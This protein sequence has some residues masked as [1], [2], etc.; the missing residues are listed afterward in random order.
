MLQQVRRW[1]RWIQLLTCEKLQERNTFSCKYSLSLLGDVRSWSVSSDT[2]S[3]E[4]FKFQ[5]TERVSFSVGVRSNKAPCGRPSESRLP[6]RM[7]GSL[8]LWCWSLE[9]IL[10]LEWTHYVGEET[11]ARVQVPKEVDRVYSIRIH[12]TFNAR[13]FFQFRVSPFLCFILVSQDLQEQWDRVDVEWRNLRSSLTSPAPWTA[14]QPAGHESEGE[15]TLASPL[16]SVTRIPFGI[17]LL[18]LT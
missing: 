4:A 8:D 16:A 3:F 11:S 10:Y 12:S 14:K 1:V 18:A 7:A 5:P 2:A 6:T 9:N 15:W 13:H 17:S